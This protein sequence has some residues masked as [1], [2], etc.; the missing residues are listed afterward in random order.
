MGG[1]GERK[2]SP[3]GFG[4]C[5]LCSPSHVLFHSAPI[6]TLREKKNVLPEAWGHGVTAKVG[7]QSM[8]GLCVDLTGLSGV[9][10]FGQTFL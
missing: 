8:L 6:V 10:V 3:L 9:C 1:D 5:E 2:G 7:K 4:K